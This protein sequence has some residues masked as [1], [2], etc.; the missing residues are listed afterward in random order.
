MWPLLIRSKRPWLTLAQ[1]YNHSGKQGQVN[2]L[3]GV[4]GYANAERALEY[5]RVITEFI[6]QPEYKDV[7]IM[8]GVVNEALVNTIGIDTVSSL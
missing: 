3:N 8:F 7:V 1:G 4:M 2:F 5:I 6:S